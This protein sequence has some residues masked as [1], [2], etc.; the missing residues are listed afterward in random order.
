M[1]ETKVAVAALA[2]ALTSVA[3]AMI[4]H[5]PVDDATIQTVVLAAVTFVTAWLAPHTPR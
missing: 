2:A 4:R 1:V 3:L 5:M